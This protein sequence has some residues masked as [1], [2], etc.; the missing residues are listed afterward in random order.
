[1]SSAIEVRL[2][3]R[4]RVAGALLAASEWPEREQAVKA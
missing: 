3:D 1:M 4:L 2:D